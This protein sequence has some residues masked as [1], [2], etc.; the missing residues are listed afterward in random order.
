MTHEYASNKVKLEELVN[1]YNEQN[2]QINMLSKDEMF[3]NEQ[4]EITKENQDDCTNDESGARMV[5]KIKE[6][7]DTLRLELKDLNIKCHV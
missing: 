6:T 3:F 1:E 5:S 7:I 2:H 4:M